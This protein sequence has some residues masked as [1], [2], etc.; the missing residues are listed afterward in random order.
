M[1]HKKKIVTALALGTLLAG[2][3]TSQASPPKAQ[4]PAKDA[5][6][7]E[8][9][10]GIQTVGDAWLLCN[11][12]DI[13]RSKSLVDTCMGYNLAIHQQAFGFAQAIIQKENLT[14]CEGFNLDQFSADIIKAYGNP[15]N[16]NKN[17]FTYTIDF[18][19]SAF[20]CDR[21]EQLAPPKAKIKKKKSTTITKPMPPAIGS[22]PT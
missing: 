5:S 19:V 22:E 15:E 4:P 11:A 2:V 3:Q 10:A 18:M 13:P 12:S 1:Q 6:A 7:A 17:Y 16:W 9:V 8:M 14:T 20:S 21:P